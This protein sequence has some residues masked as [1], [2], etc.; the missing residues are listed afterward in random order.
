M[1]NT[2]RWFRQGLGSRIDALEVA[3]QGLLSGE[4]G[5]AGTLRQIAQSL[6]APAA[7]YGLP[8]IAAAAAAAAASTPR[9]VE[10]LTKRLIVLLREE[11]ASVEASPSTVL[12][13]GGDE[14]VNAALREKLETSTRRV[15]CAA[16]WKEAQAAIRERAVS[17][18]V[19]NLHLPDQDGRLVLTQLREHSM[20]AALP[21]L[22]VL[23]PDTPTPQI[24]ALLQETDA[25]MHAPGDVDRIVAWIKARLRRAHEVQKEARR[26]PPTGMLNRAAFREQF[27]SAQK[28]CA[29]ADEPLT[30]VLLSIDLPGSMPEPEAAARAALQQVASVCS[31]SL[32]ATDIVA[33]WGAEEL[34]VLLP[35]QDQ[36]GST[37]AIGK[38]LQKMGEERFTDAYGRAIDVSVSAG[39][40]LVEPSAPL[41]NA[42]AEADG[43]LFQ[44]RRA[45]GNRIVSD[46]TE[47]RQWTDR[48]LIAT[49]DPTT[50]RVL[51][52]LLKKDGFHITAAD[53]AAAAMQAASGQHWHLVVIDEDLPGGGFRLLEELRR[54][55][56][57][58][59]TLVVTLL[60]KGEE[61]NTSRALELGASDYVIRPFS[62][63]NF[64]NRIRRLLTRGGPAGSN[65]SLPRS[66]LLV[67]DRPADVLLLTSALRKTHRY[68]L[69]LS[70]WKRASQRF[71]QER[72]DA[73]VLCLETHRGNGRPEIEAL[74]QDIR[75][76]P[77]TSIVL[78]SERDPE[79]CAAAAGITVTGALR[80]PFKA[81]TVSR[82][83][84]KLLGI[85]PAVAPVPESDGAARALNDEIRRYL[86]SC[87]ESEP[88]AGS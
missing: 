26:D 57:F 7:S 5:S 74:M 43:F 34:A 31:S 73:A 53:D 17:C 70:T 80:K 19:A 33:R 39:I 87:R 68:A 72:P 78:A 60:S 44:A 83:I 61:E 27:E 79:E 32:R 76:A 14:R 66:V 22:V 28:S 58:N 71:R 59:R 47:L 18:V 13:I 35:G 84:E 56:R 67:G 4:S 29:E 38:I 51:T 16:G 24:D 25:V 48:V 36:F 15:R 50:A 85:E 3:L 86:E 37:R 81:L 82:E 8:A 41:D 77:N 6:A 20:T 65:A 30:L 10:D 45:G 2:L 54:L 88:G 49:G 75:D 40:A 46:P 1:Q 64:M 11:A 12:I 21:I 52:T 9:T 69:L 63:F 55:S 62:P 42:A 23:Q